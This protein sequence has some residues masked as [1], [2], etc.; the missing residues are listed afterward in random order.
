VTVDGAAMVSLPLADPELAAGQVELGAVNDLRSGDAKAAFA[1]IVLKSPTVGAAPR[2]PGLA[3]AAEATSPVKLYSYDRAAHAVV[4]EPVLFLSGSGYC[5]M[6]HIK[7]SDERCDIEWTTVDSHLKIT[8]P[9]DDRPRLFTFDDPRGNGDC[10]GGFGT[11]GT[12]PVDPPAFGA[13]LKQ[14]K[15]AL[16]AISV[17]AGQVTKMAEIYTP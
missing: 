7:P 9:V 15:G 8:L 5:T 14:S 10:I 1:D 4:A 11:G 13:W 16:V 2:F 12:C 3:G 6:F 17:T